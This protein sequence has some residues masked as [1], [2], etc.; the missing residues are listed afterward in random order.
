V[1]TADAVENLAPKKSR[2]ELIWDNYMIA[3]KLPGKIT[4]D[5]KL[6]VELPQDVEPADVLVT[7]EAVGENETGLDEP[8]WTAEELAELLTPEPKTGA[9]IVAQ[10]RK[11][12]PIKFRGLTDDMDSE[13]W[14]QEQRRK[15]RE[16]NLW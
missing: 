8:L 2:I 12:A 15:R 11:E 13:E 5:G 1:A 9:E 6:I 16:R 14:V 10:L 7:I 4:T 3:L